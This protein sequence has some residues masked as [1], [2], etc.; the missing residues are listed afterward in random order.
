[1]KALRGTN[2]LWLTKSVERNST[3]FLPFFTI[4]RWGTYEWQHHQQAR[5]EKAGVF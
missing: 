2:R 1:M 3:G 4:Q 5:S